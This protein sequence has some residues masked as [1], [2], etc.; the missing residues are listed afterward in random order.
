MTD[1]KKILIIRLGA[2]GDFVQ[3]FYPFAAIRQF[4]P[5]AEIT[6]LTTKPFVELAEKSPWFDKVVVDEKPNRFN[7]YGVLKLKKKLQ[8]FD[9]IYDLQTSRRSTW[10]F[11]LVRQYKGSGIA[12]CITNRHDAVNRNE[13]HTY[14]RQ[15]DQLKKVGITDYPALDLSWFLRE[16]V[17]LIVDQPYVI[18]VPGCSKK[19]VEKRWPI[20]SYAEIAKLCVQKGILPVLIG[21]REEKKYVQ[22]ITKI[23]P[24]A[25]NIVG[26]TNLLQL[27]NLMQQAQFSLGN[28]TGPMHIAAMVGCRSVVLFSSAS[29]P[30]LTAPKGKNVTVLYEDNLYNLSVKRV[31]QELNWVH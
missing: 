12:A 13:M 28:D 29:N 10:Y 6:L 24:Q 21:S 5:K 23:C 3:S 15:K 22:Q 1:L 4:H 19:H 17:D 26:K 30:M 8:G 2:L 16:K 31:A 18:L 7:L 25:M 11:K 27:G 14:D 20:Q 9:Y